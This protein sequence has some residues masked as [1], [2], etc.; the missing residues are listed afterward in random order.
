MNLE[1]AKIVLHKLEES[2]SSSYRHV[3]L[4]KNNQFSGRVGVIIEG[5]SGS[6]KTTLLKMLSNSFNAQ[7][8]DFSYLNNYKR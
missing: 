7:Y 4:L 3:N 5:R 8:I 1:I 6:G 2:R